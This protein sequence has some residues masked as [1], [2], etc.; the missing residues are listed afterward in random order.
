MKQGQIVEEFDAKGKAGES[1]HVV[2]RYPALDDVRAA[3][4]FVNAARDEAEFLGQR[5]HETIESEKKFIQGNIE[6]MEKEKGVFLFV[7]IGGELVGDSVIRPSEFD[8]SP[9]V[10]K[11]GIML[12]EKFTGLGIGTRL[13]KKVLELAARDTRFKVIESSYFSKNIR[14]KKLH[15]L[16][17]FKQYGVFP[18]EVLLRDGSYSDHLY[19]YKQIKEL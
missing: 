17:G 19:V 13:A 14:S 3:V 6:N 9:H 4:R 11:F 1:L 15:E 12:R 18:K 7:E 16:L 8:V 2:F 10:G 5:H